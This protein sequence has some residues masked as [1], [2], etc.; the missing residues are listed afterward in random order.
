[1]CVCSPICIF[2][3]K[4]YPELSLTGSLSTKCFELPYPVQYE[5][6]QAE[7]LMF[8]SV[9]SSQN[10][11]HV[12]LDAMAL[13]LPWLPSYFSIAACLLLYV[14]CL[15]VLVSINS[16]M[17]VGEKSLKSVLKRTI[18]IFRTL[19]YRGGSRQ[20][21]EWRILPLRGEVRCTAVIVVL[22]RFPTHSWVWQAFI[23]LWLYVQ[24]RA[25]YFNHPG[26][27]WP[28]AGRTHW[29]QLWYL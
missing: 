2:S 22:W 23:S 19:S 3:K 9:K 16:S 4:T 18:S 25:A 14:S 10:Y 26:L 28:L 17:Y 6:V 29:V 11:C 13:V 21:R 8:L 24:L 12:S 20:A 5:F 15:W 1:M 7:I 27:L